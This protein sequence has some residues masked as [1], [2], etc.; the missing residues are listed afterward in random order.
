M[1]EENGSVVVSVE[2]SLAGLRAL[3]E[4][5]RQARLRGAP[6]VAVQ[7]YQQPRSDG[8]SSRLWAANDMRGAGGA[9]YVAARQDELDLERRWMIREKATTTAIQRAFQDAM[10]GLPRDV[11]VRPAAV[12]GRIGPV[13]VG[14]AYRDE[15]LLVIPA[16]R[17]RRGRLRTL[18]HYC[19]TRARC[20][21]LVVP[22]HEL[23][24][25]YDGSW[26]LW[27]RR[28]RGLTGTLPPP[29]R[30]LMGRD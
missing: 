23:A 8:P 27:Q 22:P 13:L 26:H 1:T 15:D 5:V 14:M 18:Q 29:T 19:T 16:D 10:G 21:V 9:L 7:T 17:R 12:P 3:R 25:E 4:A 28:L 11:R 6:V 2:G 30:H 20:A 24:R